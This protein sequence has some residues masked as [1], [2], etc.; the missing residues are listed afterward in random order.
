VV[1]IITATKRD[2]NYQDTDI[3]FAAALLSTTSIWPKAM[4]AKTVPAQV[5]KSF[6]VNG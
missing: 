5:R 4:V 1:N 2:V 6:A 3:F